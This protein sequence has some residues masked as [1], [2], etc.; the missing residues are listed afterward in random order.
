VI[1][2]AYGVARSLVM[3]YGPVWRR[4]RMVEFYR[5][6]LAPGDLAFDLGA[7]VGSRVR[8]FRRLGARVIAIEPQP[9]M[10]RVLATLYGRDRGVIVEPVAVADAAGETTM[11][12]SRR[13]PT[14][15]TLDQGWID[16]VRADR[17]FDP[18]AWE[19][20]R[21]VSA[22]TLD[23][24]IARHGEPRFTKID[25]EGGEPAVLAGLGRPLA[26]LSFEYLA[27]ARGQAIACVER[28]GAL[29]DYRFRPSSGESLRWDG[30]WL[31]ADGIRRHL[32]SR[33]LDGRS[34]DV[35][36]LRRDQPVP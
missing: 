11:R 1:E 3:Y 23:A 24:L 21:P 15:S 14:L 25:I 26:S 8:A 30:P 17:R 7:H 19:A 27:V 35:Y 32:A 6:F 5:Q 2:R 20:A 4:R 16:T 13:T 12:I 34:G 28:L 33:P 18:I 10:V 9:D 31:E 36:A 29:G 22:T